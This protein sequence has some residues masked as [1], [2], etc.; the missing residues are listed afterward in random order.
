MLDSGGAILSN[1]SDAVEPLGEDVGNRGEVALDRGALL[2]ALIEHLHESAQAN[3][4]QEGDNQ[5]WHRTA[6]RRLRYQQPVV[7]RFRDRL[8]QSLD[9][10]GLDT[11]VRRVNTRHAL[12]PLG[13]SFCTPFGRTPVTSESQRIESSFGGLSRVNDSLMQINLVQRRI[14]LRNT[15]KNTAAVSPKRERIGLT[16]A[17]F[18]RVFRSPILRWTRFICINESLTLD[19]PPKLDSNRCDSEVTGVLPNG[20]QKDLPGRLKAWRVFTRRTR[21]C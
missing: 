8:R 15:R 4:D 7:G 21:V 9:R 16:A 5:G 19:S 2:P 18:L 1:G 10:I 17:V 6:K 11:R 12:S 13:R 14:G 20:V 3:G